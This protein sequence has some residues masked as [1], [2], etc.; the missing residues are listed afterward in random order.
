MSAQR[1]R[2]WHFAA[3]ILAL[4]LLALLAPV[5]AQTPVSADPV[6]A[7]LIAELDGATLLAYASQ[8]SGAAPA[9]VGGQPY[10]FVTR[11]TTSGTPIAK[12]TQ[13]VYEFMQARGLNVRY[14]AWSACGIANRNVVA[15]KT[16]KSSPGEVVLVTAHVDSIS[17]HG[18]APGADDNASGTAAVLHIAEIVA[19]A[20]FQRT[21]QFV[22]FTGEEQ[23][24]CG[25]EAF[26]RQAAT[27]GTN[28]VAVYNMD[29]IA[30]DA[31]EEP[32]LRLHTRRTGHA[33]YAADAEIANTFIG[34]VADYGLQRQLS[35]QI[36]AD[37]NDENDVYS[38]WS[39]GFPG[40][41]AIE[42]DGP[43][44]DDFNPYY[45]TSR[46]TV[47][48]F[49]QAYY[50]NFVKASVGTVALLARVAPSSTPTPAPTPVG[51]HR[52]YLPVTTR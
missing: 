31:D 11:E 47:S 4:T 28:I 30:Y 39:H 3:G 33:G 40:I 13:Y 36:L 25:S 10:T 7:A 41:L 48:A 50:T 35:P 2:Q 15:E 42:D 52:L 14:E 18:N 8:L 29:M 12:A 46:D 51:S 5:Q 32:I 1:L 43:V 20:S 37:G 38:F 22:L 44:E 49:N 19:D 9:M 27:A 17:E 34:V 26:A 6:V 16:G 45:H 24:L 23:G 21:L